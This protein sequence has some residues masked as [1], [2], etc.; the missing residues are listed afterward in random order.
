MPA[1]LLTQQNI[2]TGRG[3]FPASGWFFDALE[4]FM[5][6]LQEWR[7]NHQN[8]D[9]PNGTLTRNGVL[10][11]SCKLTFYFHFSIG[12]NYR[13]AIWAKINNVNGLDIWFRIGFGE[14]T[15]DTKK[16]DIYSKCQLNATSL[17]CINQGIHYF[18]SL[19]LP[20]AFN[21]SGIYKTSNT[22]QIQDFKDI[23]AMMCT[24]MTCVCNAICIK[25]KP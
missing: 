18:K 24:W 5:R 10:C 3:L 21:V 9:D 25:Q 6:K 11:G 13:N 20:E 7:S 4:Q 16:I 22:V 14:F 23:F 8:H 12:G 1:I 19:S 17:K 15:A 2:N